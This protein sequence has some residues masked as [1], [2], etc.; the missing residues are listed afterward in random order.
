MSS[1]NKRCVGW[2][3]V[4]GFLD[5]VKE[6]PCQQLGTWPGCEGKAPPPTPPPE[7]FGLGLPMPS[8]LPT[9][10][11]RM[12]MVAALTGPPGAFLVPTVYRWENE[13]SVVQTTP[14]VAMQPTPA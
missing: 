12:S 4:V 1:K 6:T 2:W 8:F 7:P 14:A 10:P 3:A 13:K 11:P 9:L 5:F